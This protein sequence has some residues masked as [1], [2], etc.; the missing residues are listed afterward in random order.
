VTLPDANPQTPIGKPPVPP[1]R[2]ELRGNP[3]DAHAPTA[4]T[5]TRSGDDDSRDR[6]HANDAMSDN[7]VNDETVRASEARVTVGSEL[8]SPPALHAAAD[9]FDIADRPVQDLDGSVSDSDRDDT[10]SDDEGDRVALPLPQEAQDRDDT[11]SRDSDG[12]RDHNQDDVAEVMSGDDPEAFGPIA[13][14]EVDLLMEPGMLSGDRLMEYFSDFDQKSEAEIRAEAKSVYEALASTP[15][16]TVK[17]EE[18][19][20]GKMQ[21]VLRSGVLEQ[22]VDRS[23]FSADQ[24]ALYDETVSRILAL[25]ARHIDIAVIIRNLFRCDDR[26]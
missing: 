23:D 5:V 12:A 2:D 4:D 26:E 1:K 14:V 11:P 19:S 3:I 24:N 18:V 8:E 15:G 13:E 7:T 20:L 9:P 6:P 17:L 10:S 21:D 25:K 16:V 22:H